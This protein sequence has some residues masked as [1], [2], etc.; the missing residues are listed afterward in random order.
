[1]CA[2]PN[3]ENPSSS[4]YANR[5][6]R[7]RWK[8]PSKVHQSLTRHGRISWR[9]SLPWHQDKHSCLLQAGAQPHTCTVPET[10]EETDKGFFFVFQEQNTE[11]LEL[12]S[13][14]Q[15]GLTVGLQP[16]L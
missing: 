12:H 14:A 8:C 7:R 6:S 2:F 15:P 11:N 1:M 3:Q 5:I 13:S 10:S 16:L 4:K 9:D